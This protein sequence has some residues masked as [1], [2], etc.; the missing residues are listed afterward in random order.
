M[1]QVDD[2]PEEQPGGGAGGEP[3]Q[4]AGDV[5]EVPGRTAPGPQENPQQAKRRDAQQRQRMGHVAGPRHQP[6]PAGPAVNDQERTGD[7]ETGRQQLRPGEVDLVDY[8]WRQ[9]RKCNNEEA[10][11]RTQHRGQ[12]PE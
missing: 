6:G 12:Q 3:S 8:E 9:C 1:P 5:A 7:H 4:P 10:G 11:G 2:S